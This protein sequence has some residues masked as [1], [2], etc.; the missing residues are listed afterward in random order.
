MIKYLIHLFVQDLKNISLDNNSPLMFSVRV[1]NTKEINRL[2][3][4]H[5]SFTNILAFSQIHTL[6]NINPE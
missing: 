6:K 4:V 1:A 2:I 3:I 5:G